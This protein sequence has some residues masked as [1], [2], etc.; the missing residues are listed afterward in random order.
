MGFV[1]EIL[2]EAPAGAKQVQKG[3]NVTVHCTGFGKDR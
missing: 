3:Q 2:T 1:K